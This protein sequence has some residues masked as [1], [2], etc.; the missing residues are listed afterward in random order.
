[1][2]RRIL[3]MACGLG[4]TIMI[5]ALWVL[6]GGGG[7][8]AYANGDPHTHFRYGHYTWTQAGGNTI[9]VTLQNAFRRNGYSC[10]DLV[11]LGVVPCTGPDGLPGVGDVIAEFIGFTQF[12]WGDG[13]PSV[14]SPIGPLLYLVTSIDPANNWLFGLAL[15]PASLP[16]IDASLSHTY[17]APGNY[18]AF[19]DS[20]CR[21]SR[22]A[23]VN[24]HINNPD[25]GYRVE[26][27]INVGT[28]NNSPI[29]ALPPIILCPIDALCTF[30][31]PGAD[32]DGDSL[33]FR[34]STP[35]E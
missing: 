1:M 5:V 13:S 27:I 28:T 34:L 17:A 23:G 32:P 22:V 12:D 10:R 3:L 19:T 29:S 8:A 35:A 25:G 24:E 14:G 9:E 26:T 21:I 18:T 20:C 16:A 6:F 30:L 11:S 7:E 15:D 2:L 4:A 33:N 31:V